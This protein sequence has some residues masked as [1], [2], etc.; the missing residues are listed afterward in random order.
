MKLTRRQSIISL[1]ALGIALGLVDVTSFAKLETWHRWTNPPLLAVTTSVAFLGL[2]LATIV[3]LTIA[4]RLNL[5]KPIRTRLMIGGI[6]L[7]LVQ[8][9]ANILISFQYAQQNL[10]IAVLIDFF[11]L[12]PDIALK[13]NAVIAGGFLSVISITFWQVLAYMLDHEMQRR[14]EEQKQF[15]DLDKLFAEEVQS[16]DNV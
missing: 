15:A 2:L 11:N 4:M 3:A 5:P 1:I 13:A 8:G 9:L 7:S 16:R 6:A 10:P 14:Q 12:R